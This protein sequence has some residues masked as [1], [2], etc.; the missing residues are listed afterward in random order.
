M[1]KFNEE[2]LRINIKYSENPCEWNNFINFFISFIIENDIL[3]N[4]YG[5]KETSNGGR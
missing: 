1:K 3:G 2:N 4:V 5:D